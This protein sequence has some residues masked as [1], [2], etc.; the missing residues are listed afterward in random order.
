MAVGE[1]NKKIIVPVDNCK[2]NSLHTNKDLL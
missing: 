1:N 2:L